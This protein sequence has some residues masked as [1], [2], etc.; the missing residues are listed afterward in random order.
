MKRF[1]FKLGTVLEYKQQILDVRMVE[2]GAA[3]AKVAQQEAVCSATLRQL[4]EYNAEYTQRKAEGLTV[5]EAME[6]QNCMEV[7]QVTLKRENEKLEDL[8]RK[9]NEARAR[10]VS[11]RQETF[12]LEKLRDMQKK[13][14]NTA[15]AKAEEVALED[16]TAARRASS[17]MQAV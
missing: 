1:Q 8:R 3:R 2:H 5:L 13:E 9:E 14:Y 17:A 10:V 15:A 12:S 7:L 6:Y 4:Q 16:L 11:A